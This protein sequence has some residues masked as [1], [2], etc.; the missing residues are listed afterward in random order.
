MNVTCR[1]IG[2]RELKILA[3]FMQSIAENGLFDDVP[4]T[5]AY[6]LHNDCA[7]CTTENGE[8]ITSKNI[9]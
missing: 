4:V 7:Y 3:E 6:D 5:F 8:K 1:D 9:A 2:Y